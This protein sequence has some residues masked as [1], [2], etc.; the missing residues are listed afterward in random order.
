LSAGQSGEPEDVHLKG[1]P[2]DVYSPPRKIEVKAS[3]GSARGAAIPLED[4][5]V[6]AARLDPA[7]YYAYIVDNVPSQDQITLRVL[8]GQLLAKM[9]DRTAPHITYWPTIR[10]SDYD[11][12]PV[13][14]Q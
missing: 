11:H 8:H 12:L 2:Y 5:Q 3:S 1:L 4:R 6:K 9:L 13:G 14:L 10:V 7:N